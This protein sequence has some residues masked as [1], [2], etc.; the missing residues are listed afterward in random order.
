MI[1][2]VQGQTLPRHFARALTLSASKTF[3]HFSGPDSTPVVSL[4]HLSAVRPASLAS[5]ALCRSSRPAARCL[6]FAA[7]W[8]R[9]CYTRGRDAKPKRPSAA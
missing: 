2:C 9:K 7:D 3:V 8:S 5:P 6:D 1:V 4:T